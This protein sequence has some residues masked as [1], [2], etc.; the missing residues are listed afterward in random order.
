[1]ADKDN[2]KIEDEKLD[3]VS[4]GG[5]FDMYTEGDYNAAGVEVIGWGY[6]YNDG[7]KFQGKEISS[8]DA[9]R[10]VFF[11]GYNGRPA[12]SLEE[13]YEFYEYMVGILEW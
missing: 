5:L 6:L 12:Y 8:T 11:T 10:L 9:N 7:Y 1:M 3:K 13:A 4:G 2:K